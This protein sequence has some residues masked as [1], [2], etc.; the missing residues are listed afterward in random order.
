[1]VHYIVTTRRHQAWTIPRMH[2][3][4]SQPYLYPCVGGAY[5]WTPDQSHLYSRNYFIILLIPQSMARRGRELHRPTRVYV[6]SEYSR[7]QKK[8]IIRKKNIIYI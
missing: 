8:F 4:N 3:L 5:I 6:A 7:P 2:V 1:M